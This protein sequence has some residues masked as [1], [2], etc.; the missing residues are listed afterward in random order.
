[1]NLPN[2]KGGLKASRKGFFSQI[3]LSAISASV[4]PI[5]CPMLQRF[6]V[7][8]GSSFRLGM[9]LQMRDGRICFGYCYHAL[10]ISRRSSVRVR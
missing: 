5:Y 4:S 3:V 6:Y 1:M 10:F 9:A 7:P 2:F 8:Q